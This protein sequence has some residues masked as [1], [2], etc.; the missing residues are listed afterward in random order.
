MYKIMRTIDLYMKK[1]S[2]F[3]FFPVFQ[4]NQ[5]HVRHHSKNWTNPNFTSLFCPNHY[6]A[7]RARPNKYDCCDKPS[8]TTL[9]LQQKPSKPQII[10]KVKFII[11]NNNDLSLISLSHKF[12]TIEIFE[13]GKLK[14]LKAEIFNA[15]FILKNKRY[16][17]EN[18]IFFLIVS[19][20]QEI[21]NLAYFQK[22]RIPNLC[23][24][25]NFRQLR[26]CSWKTEHQEKK[27]FHGNLY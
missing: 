1:H 17:S 3:A 27:W 21:E 12:Q 14:T 9:I 15:D 25:W 5:C 11:S 7:L 13:N 23:E 24:L 2:K 26:F 6:R 4:Q 10:S 20:I 22:F 8:G 19:I 18:F 16:A